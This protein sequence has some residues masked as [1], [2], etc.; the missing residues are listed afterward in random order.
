MSFLPTIIHPMGKLLSSYDRSKTPSAQVDPNLRIFAQ[1][2]KIREEVF[3]KDQGVALDNELDDDDARSFHWV[4]YV[5]VS[6]KPKP[7]ILDSD[8]TPE[9]LAD[10]A[11]RKQK[12]K[13]EDK[14]QARTRAVSSS[15]IAVGTVRL[16]PPRHP[17]HKPD[18]QPGTANAT[19][20][21]EINTRK[22]SA[23]FQLG[24]GEDDDT[25]ADTMPG[26]S[27]LNPN[28]EPYIKLGRLAVLKEYRG[29]RLGK[30]LLNT[31]LEF[32]RDHPYTLVP[33][34]GIIDRE[35]ANLAERRRLSASAGTAARGPSG[36]VERHVGAD[37]WKGLVCAHAQVHLVKMYKKWGFESDEGM[38]TWW[39]EG[40]EHMGMWKRLELKEENPLRRRSGSDRGFMDR[41]DGGHV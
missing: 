6:K 20:N 36:L 10:E 7:F 14:D 23:N 8:R 2:M 17:P 5:N 34:L 4:I 12:E 30:L 39:E 25:H 24:D 11:A 1:A 22:P 41:H 3:V 37:D 40:I 15:R 18:P 9:E 16:V 21:A 19:D 29:M 35:N 32:A 13:E 38:G 27:T 31:A 28:D 33:R 26:P